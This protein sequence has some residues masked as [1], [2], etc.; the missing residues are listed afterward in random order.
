VIGTFHACVLLTDE[1][2]K[3][4]GRNDDGRLGVGNTNI[5]FA[6]TTVFGPGSGVL[7]VSAGDSITFFKTQAGVL[8]SGGNG[9]SLGE[10][11]QLNNGTIDNQV[12]PVPMSSWY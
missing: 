8:V 5:Q 12:S 1:S 10:A 7:S 3:C 4:W 11:R 2:V 9:S 6:P